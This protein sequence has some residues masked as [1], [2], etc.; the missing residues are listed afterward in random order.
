MECRGATLQASLAG[1]LGSVWACLAVALELSQQL[2]CV[3][4][5]LVDINITLQSLPGT[6]E[7]ARASPTS[8]IK[9]CDLIVRSLQAYLSPVSYSFQVSTCLK[10]LYW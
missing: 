7:A 10:D 8:S 9:H 6:Q 2:A 5:E 4:P 3:A 1:H